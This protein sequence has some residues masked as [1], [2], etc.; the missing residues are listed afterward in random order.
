MNCRAAE[1][2]TIDGNFLPE[3]P[4]AMP[5]YSFHFEGHTWPPGVCCN[6]WTNFQLLD[7]LQLEWIHVLLMSCVDYYYLFVSDYELNGLSAYWSGC[8]SFYI[9]Y[10]QGP[11]VHVTNHSWKKGFIHL[12]FRSTYFYHFIISS[13][14]WGFFIAFSF[15]CV[16]IQIYGGY[17]HKALRFGLW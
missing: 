7:S 17:V 5:S 6:S 14:V 3:F 9:F 1:W 12:L 15:H 16:F 11:D 13:N 10:L 4:W 2:F 8:N